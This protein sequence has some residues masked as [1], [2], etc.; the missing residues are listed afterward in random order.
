MHPYHTRIRNPPPNTLHDFPPPHV[1]L[2]PEDAASKVFL[3]VARAFVS[4]VS[5]LT[6]LWPPLTLPRTTA[7]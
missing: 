3:A 1:V 5:P 6:M 2:H 4:V 7:P